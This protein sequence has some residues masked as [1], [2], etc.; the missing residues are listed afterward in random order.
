MSESEQPSE[1][2]GQRVA[3]QDE[4]TIA[5]SAEYYQQF[6]ACL[7]RGGDINIDASAVSR[8]DAAFVQLLYLVQRE[9]AEGGRTLRW[10]AVSP[11]FTES[12]GLLGLSEPLALPVQA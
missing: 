12:V 2:S 3:L 9:L 5:C 7:E 10:E 6:L 8:V 1:A 4:L 11:A